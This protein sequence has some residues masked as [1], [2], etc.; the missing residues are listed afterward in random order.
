MRKYQFI[1]DI[2]KLP[3]VDEVWLY[4]S[5]ARGDN[6]ERSD[7]DIAILSKDATNPQWQSIMAIVD[8]ANLCFL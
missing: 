2:S 7:F 4:G 3:F 8:N 5:R 6:A 1:K